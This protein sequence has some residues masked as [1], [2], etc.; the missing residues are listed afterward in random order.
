MGEWNKI[1]YIGKIKFDP[2][3][4]TKKHNEQASWKRVAMIVFE[5]DITEYYAWFIFKRYNLILNPPLRGGHITFINDS[6]KDLMAG[7]RTIE[8]VDASWKLVNAK[9][10][11]KYIPVTLN[12]DVRTDG[13][14]WWLNVHHDH[15]KMLHDIRA[16]LGLSH[17]F[18]GFHMTVGY[19]NER[20]IHHSQYIH[21]LVKTNLIV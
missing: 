20:W 16:E 3:N 14:H 18:W 6:N 4:V 9:W 10:N 8:E 11:D 13:K 1:T 17:P 21:E 12:V 2:E 19:A 5:G 7:G 15:R